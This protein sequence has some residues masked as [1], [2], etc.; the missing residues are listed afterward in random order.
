MPNSHSQELS[1]HGVRLNALNSQEKA[2][3]LTILQRFGEWQGI[4]D[5]DDRFDFIDIIRRDLIYLFGGEDTVRILLSGPVGMLFESTVEQTGLQG[6]TNGAS[7]PPTA[8]LRPD[9]TR[10]LWSIY[11]RLGYTEQKDFAAALDVDPSGISRVFKN[12]SEPDEDQAESKSVGITIRRLNKVL[13]KIGVFPRSDFLWMKKEGGIPYNPRETLNTPEGLS[14]REWHLVKLAGYL[15]RVSERFHPHSLHNFREQYVELT[16]G[17]ASSLLWLEA[18]VG[19]AGKVSPNRLSQTACDI[20]AHA[21]GSKPALLALPREGDSPND[22]AV[23]EDL[24]AAIFGLGPTCCFFDPSPA[25]STTTES[26]LSSWQF[27]AGSNTGSLNQS[28]AHEATTGFSQMFSEFSYAFCRETAARALLPGVKEMNLAFSSWYREAEKN[29]EALAAIEFIR[30]RLDN[31]LTEF[32][33]DKTK[34]QTTQRNCPELIESLFWRFVWETTPAIQCC[35]DNYEFSEWKTVLAKQQV[36]KLQHINKKLRE[37]CNEL[38]NTTVHVFVSRKTTEDK[39]A[40]REDLAKIAAFNELDCQF[41]LTLADGFRSPQSANPTVPERPTRDHSLFR[42]LFAVTTTMRPIRRHMS[43]SG[44]QHILDEHEAI[45]ESLKKVLDTQKNAESLHYPAVSR[46]SDFIRAHYRHLFSSPGSEMGRYDAPFL[47]SLSRLVAQLT[48]IDTY[49]DLTSLWENC[50]VMVVLQQGVV[51]L[52]QE[53]AKQSDPSDPKAK[54]V[55]AQM[56]ISLILPRLVQNTG[57]RQSLSE[58]PM[59]LFLLGNKNSYLASSALQR[60]DRNNAT[61]WIALYEEAQKS[62]STLIGRI[63]DVCREAF[64]R[65]H[66]DNTD[67][68]AF[69]RL[70]GS[71]RNLYPECVNQTSGGQ[72]KARKAF[73]ERLRAIAQECITLHLVD[74]PKY[75]VWVGESKGVVWST[76]V[77]D[78][79]FTYRRRSTSTL[80]NIGDHHDDD[81]NS[82][83][84]R[85]IVDSIPQRKHK[86]TFQSNMFRKLDF[87]RHKCLQWLKA[88]TQGNLNEN[89]KGPNSHI[90]HPRT[91]SQT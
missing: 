8:P 85:A 58:Q 51:S 33:A 49:G 88:D 37:I 60:G 38:R 47:N 53:L 16:R 83:V 80:F 75:A 67:T 24:R 23:T 45:I 19:N 40:S 14:V 5:A 30:R 11:V 4:A 6:A 39:C 71:I 25:K 42:R 20:V 78:P 77:G 1:L 72:A 22:T 57:D 73:C 2:A 64:D 82:Q 79:M 36:E 31:K 69:G 62:T 9:V 56:A 91:A 28:L 17:V 76:S 70:C 46:L 84:A 81:R 55:F 50:Q 43:A 86:T 21:L 52:E 34:Q 54:E 10:I 27:E 90:T 18:T 7:G 12:L 87:V 59:L 26:P 65:P 15:G 32:W 48:E 3:A 29:N 63:V 89:T 13:K 41:H 66:A 74:I 68:H 61:Q 44:R 35:S